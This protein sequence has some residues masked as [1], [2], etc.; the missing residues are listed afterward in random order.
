MKCKDCYHFDVCANYLHDQGYTLGVDIAATKC[1]FYKDKSR[2]IE[3]PCKV[4]DTL[5]I[6]DSE[7]E[8]GPIVKTIC[9][10]IKI[11]SEDMWVCSNYDEFYFDEFGVTVFLTREA[12]EQALKERENNG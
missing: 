10:E 12:A 9:T 5:F 3:L 8:N 6:V 7:Y 1:P 4:G 11:D 2:I